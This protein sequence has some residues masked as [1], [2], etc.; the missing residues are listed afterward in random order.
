MQHSENNEPSGDGHGPD[1][2]TP[3]KPLVS[4]AQCGSTQLYPTSAQTLRLG[5]VLGR[6]CPECEHRDWV[7]TNPLAASL[8]YGRCSRR[9][10]ELRALAQA[11]LDGLHRD[12]D[13]AFAEFAR[14]DDEDTD[15]AAPASIAA[16]AEEG[17]DPPCT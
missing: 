11:P 7:T 14:A 1:D 5:V 16:A 2:A 15:L 13:E 12:L 3:S 6:R 17:H 9:Y 4:C 8:W 10:Q